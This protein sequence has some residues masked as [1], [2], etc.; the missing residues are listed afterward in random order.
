MHLLTTS[1]WGATAERAIKTFAQALL[2]TLT[3][4]AGTAE[5]PTLGVHQVGWLGALSVAA[6]AA[7]LSVLTSITTA[8][9][10]TPTA[11]RSAEEATL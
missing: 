5:I 11:K 3:L 10:V 6:L 8:G 7:V 2:A 9:S 1:F 4:A